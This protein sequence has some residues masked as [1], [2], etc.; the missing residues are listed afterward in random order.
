MSDPV[1]RLTVQQAAA[2]VGRSEETIRRWI[3]QGRLEAITHPLLPHR[4]VSE[5]QLLQVEA[6]SRTAQ[7][8]SLFGRRSA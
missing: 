2:R 5:D 6:D 8:D 1:I 3:R 4:W 7:R